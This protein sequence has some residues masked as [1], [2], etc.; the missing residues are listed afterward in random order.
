ATSVLLHLSL[1]DALPI[2]HKYDTHDY[3]K[4]DPVFGD[5]E[6]FDDLIAR[7][8]AQ[9]IRVV[10]DGVFNHCGLGFAPFADVIEKGPAS[11]YRDWR[12]EEHTSALQSR[13]NLVC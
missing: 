2:Y 10:L 12:S 8:H 7:A 5:D 1:H 13:E 4:I 3:F 9:G 11:R 6:V